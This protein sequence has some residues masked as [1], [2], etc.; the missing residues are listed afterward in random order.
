MSSRQLAA[1]D[2]NDD[3]VQASSSICSLCVRDSLIEIRSHDDFCVRLLLNARKSSMCVFTLFFPIEILFLSVPQHTHLH[4][5]SQS[6]TC[7]D[8]HHNQIP[9]IAHELRCSAVLPILAERPNRK[10]ISVVGIC[11]HT[12]SVEDAGDVLLWPVS[13]LLLH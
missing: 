1:C 12:V 4:R 9:P 13:I 3:D 8:A 2:D 7:V 5:Q 11:D 10:Y 6:K